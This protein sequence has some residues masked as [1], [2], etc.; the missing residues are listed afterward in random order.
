MATRPKKKPAARV[1]TRKCGDKKTNGYRRTRV[2]AVTKSLAR[3]SKLHRV[4]DNVFVP[5]MQVFATKNLPWLMFHSC[6]GPSGR[7]AFLCALV[8]SSLFPGVLY[9]TVP[10]VGVK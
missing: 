10:G 2:S 5:R 9:P 7:R 8:R 1:P 6:L 3:V 4:K